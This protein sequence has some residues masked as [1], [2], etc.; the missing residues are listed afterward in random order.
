MFTDIQTE[1]EAFFHGL[2]WTYIFMYVMCLY[3]IK[4]NIEFDW[5]NE[6]LDR[7]KWSSKLKVWIA[8]VIVGLFFCFFTYMKGPGMLNSEYVSTLLRSWI[9][10]IVFNTVANSRIQK[11]IGD[12]DKKDKI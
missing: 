1:I 5:Y 6:L 11:S 7:K 2:N 4:N 3:G 9:I 8:G 12:L 10:V